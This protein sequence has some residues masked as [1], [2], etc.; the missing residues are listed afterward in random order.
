MRIASRRAHAALVARAAR[1]DAL[2]DPDLLLRQL[3]VE[4]RVLLRLRVQAFLAAA[5][6]VGVVAGPVG[7]LAAVELDDAGGQRAQEAPVVGDEDQRARPALEEA[8]QPVDG[9]DVEVV[10]GLVEQQHVG[11]RHQ[12]ARQQHAALHA[13]GQLA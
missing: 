4:E 12:R 1:L 3:L 5:Q 8:F 11:R 10:G 6:V 13:A 9:L 2:P 7:D